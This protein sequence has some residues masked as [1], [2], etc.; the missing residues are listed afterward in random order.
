MAHQ[1]KVG[2]RV[3]IVY[4]AAY[5]PTAEQATV[6]EVREDGSFLVQR[7]NGWMGVMPDCSV[8]GWGKGPHVFPLG[9]KEVAQACSPNTEKLR[10]TGNPVVDALVDLFEDEEG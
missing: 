8:P 2:D 3:E 10:S 6:I 4:T 5:F 1:F 9:S 7:Q